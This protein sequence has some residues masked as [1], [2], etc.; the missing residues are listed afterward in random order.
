MADTLARAVPLDIKLERVEAADASMD[1][2]VS[3]EA[4]ADLQAAFT[5]DPEASKVRGHPAASLLLFAV[6]FFFSLG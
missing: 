4:I 1:P 6:F 3:A 5:A 2:K